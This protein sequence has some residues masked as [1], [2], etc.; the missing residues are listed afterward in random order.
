MKRFFLEDPYVSYF[1]ASII[2]LWDRIIYWWKIMYSLQ[3]PPHS[4]SMLLV[5]LPQL[6]VW[7]SYLQ[8]ESILKVLQDRAPLLASFILK[9]PF[10]YGIPDDVWTLINYL[11][12]LAV[13]PYEV[14]APTF[15]SPPPNRKFSFF[16][17]PPQIHSPHCYSIDQLS[18]SKRKNPEDDDACRKYSSTHPTLIPGIF[19]IYCEHGICC[20]FEVMQSTF[21]AVP[22]NGKHCKAVPKSSITAT[23]RH[24]QVL[25]P[26]WREVLP[27][28]LAEGVWDSTAWGYDKY[29]IHLCYF[30][31]V[32][33]QNIQWELSW[34][35]C[36]LSL[37]LKICQ[38]GS[39]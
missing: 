31:W 24:C 35:R 14:V 15:L 10:E 12:D 13:V 7:F 2:L 23:G 17:N 34:F 27:V 3:V 37:I 6:S 29:Y 33:M 38:H 5:W 21:I 16:P 20:G 1:H 39:H 36:W 30:I 32:Q 19:T 22:I 4:A 25:H 26:R 28:Q 9:L 11:C 8:K 18:S